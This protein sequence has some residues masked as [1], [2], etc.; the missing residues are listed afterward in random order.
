MEQS[1][2]HFL[3]PD[4]YESLASCFICDHASRVKHNTVKHESIAVFSNNTLDECEVSPDASKEDR[5][6]IKTEVKD[7]NGVRF[8]E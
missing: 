7:V 4:V 5:I 2:I 3:N 1:K 8:K 6:D